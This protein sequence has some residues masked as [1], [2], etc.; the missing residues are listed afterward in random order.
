MTRLSDILRASKALLLGLTLLCLLAQ[1]VL[2]A[3]HELHE[4]THAH[5]GA[6]EAGPG[7]AAADEPARPGALERLLHVFDCCLHAT[8]L[9]APGEAWRP[10]HLPSPSPHALLPVDIP[11]PVARFLRPPI[12]A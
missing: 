4:S 7:D 11:S 2:A 9:P 10:R 8:A 1:P 3:A 6:D 12:A 5:A